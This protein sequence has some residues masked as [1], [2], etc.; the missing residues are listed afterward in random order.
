MIAAT[1]GIN[2]IPFTPA[3]IGALAWWD[4]SDLSTMFQNSNGTTAVAADSD[5]IGYIADKSGNGLH[6]T[7][8]TAG[9][10]PLYKTSGGLGWGQFDGSDDVLT[11]NSA[12]LR[13]LGDLT[14]CAGVYKNAAATFGLI[15]TCQTLPG[16]N[17]PFEWRFENTNP[18]RPS[19]ISADAATAETDF[20]TVVAVSTAAATV[21]S[22]RRSIGATIEH[23]ANGV[24]E[25][26]THT[27]VPTSTAGSIFSMGDW[28]T[29][30]GTVPLLGRIYSAAIYSSNLSAAS[31][32]L[33]ETYMGSKC[34]VI[35]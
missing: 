11:I 32:A 20:A 14:L 1:G 16:T 7:Q 25:V 26:M 4:F 12:V 5:P 21:L 31:L 34:G 2:P 28:T 27:K 3:S 8:A 15:M 33:L 17:N 6:L 29:S 35:L 9:L 10:R 22:L 19:F 13:L 30:P 24:R 23:S 18:I